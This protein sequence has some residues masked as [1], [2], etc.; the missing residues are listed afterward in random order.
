[1]E[2]NYFCPFLWWNYGKESVGDGI[3]PPCER[4]GKGRVRPGKLLCNKERKEG[5]CRK[6]VVG[7]WVIQKLF[8]VNR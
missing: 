5:W 2:K 3:K 8:K 4:K 1:M 6:G 7:F